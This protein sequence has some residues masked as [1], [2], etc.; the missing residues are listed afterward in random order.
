V[1]ADGAWAL[2]L[3]MGRGRERFELSGCKG[4][5]LEVGSRRLRAC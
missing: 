5:G 3:L 1:K 2:V 4:V